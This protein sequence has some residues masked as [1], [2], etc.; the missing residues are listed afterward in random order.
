MTYKVNLPLNKYWL[1]TLITQSA[2]KKKLIVFCF[3]HAGSIIIFL[4]WQPS[5]CHSNIYTAGWLHTWCWLE[6]S[7]IAK[8]I[9]A[10]TLAIKHTLIILISY[11]KFNWSLLQVIYLELQAKHTH[12]FQGG[13]QIFLLCN[14]WSTI[15]YFFVLSKFLILFLIFYDNNTKQHRCERRMTFNRKK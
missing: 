3:S 8:L 1:I 2:N 9:A 13:K 6:I 15:K 12:N 5:I 14:L 10:M 7:Y 4:A 11:L